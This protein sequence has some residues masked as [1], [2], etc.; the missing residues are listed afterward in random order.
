[1][2]WKIAATLIVSAGILLGAFFTVPNFD[3][4]GISG[5]FTALAPSSQTII[6]VS[7][8]LTPQGFSID[9][10]ADGLTVAWEG[11]GAQWFVGSNKLDLGESSTNAFVIQGWKGKIIAT[12]GGA[13][14]LEGSADSITV[15]GMK[16]SGSGRQTLKVTDL[17]FTSFVAQGLSFRGFKLATATGT[18]T[19]GNGK[20][21]L[22]A[23]GEPLELGMFNGDLAIDE[24]LRM[25]GVTDKLLLSGKSKLS[26]G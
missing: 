3:T 10:P 11:S 5:F 20:A 12:T 7:M 4:G 14:T 21:T 17:V 13:L 24:T 19:T 26:I 15:N 1:M 16:L 25:A 18:I 2:D 8:S 9:S 23:E 22:V 6:S